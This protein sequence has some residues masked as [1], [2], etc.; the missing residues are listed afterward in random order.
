MRHAQ[1]ASSIGHQALCIDTVRSVSDDTIKFAQRAFGESQLLACLGMEA[2]AELAP[3][4]QRVDLPSRARISTTDANGRDHCLFLT[5]G[6]AS[7]ALIDRR[8]ERIEVAVVG[9]ECALGLSAF[10]AGDDEA[11]ITMLVPGSAMKIDRTELARL[12]AH[13]TEIAAMVQSAQA[14]L[15]QQS[16]SSLL[17][18]ARY[19]VEQRVA[20]WL[21]IATERARLDSLPVTHETIAM[22]LGVRRAGVSLALNALREKQ[23]IECSRRAIAVVDRALLSEASAGSYTAIAREQVKF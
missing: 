10:A 11:R 17:A 22:A 14:D 16:A 8:R 15:L 13:S 9:R 21:L 19:D 3:L 4:L 18:A 7:C 2:R 20:R 12:S 6:L 23:A 5:S 1:L